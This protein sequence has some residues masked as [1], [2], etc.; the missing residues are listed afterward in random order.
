[1]EFDEKPRIGVLRG[2]VTLLRRVCL[3]GLATLA[4][5]AP[6]M[7]DPFNHVVN[8]G[9]ES[10]ATAG[11]LSP[12]LAG[13][14]FNYVIYVFGVGGATN[15]GGWTVSNSSNNNGSSTPLSVLVT[16]NPP[17]VP[18]G[19]SYAVDFDPYWN[20]TTGALL[21][22]PVT[23]TLP[24]IS[25]TMDLPAGNYVLSFEGA[26]ETLSPPASR[27]LNVTLTGA[28]ALNQTVTTSES[29]AVGYNQFTFDFSSTGGNVTLTF[30]PN[31]Y[32]PEPNFMLDNVS[33]TAVPESSSGL[34]LLTML[35]AVLALRGKISPPRR[36][37]QVR[38]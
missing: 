27:P 37:Q 30:T 24:E 1:M 22:G 17:Q 14:P 21:N 11:V 26:V 15:I 23:G 29:D 7:A 31:D 6:A 18:A 38:P 12:S 5:T 20:I 35:A 19:G 9:F 34:L 28:A 3:A 10:G 36:A 16:G 13:P 32:S 4:L 2:W 25:Q 8:G 33:V